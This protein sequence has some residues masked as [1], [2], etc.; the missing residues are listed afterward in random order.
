MIKTVICEIYMGKRI[1]TFETN[2]PALE[3]CS[4]LTIVQFK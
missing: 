3:R 1:Q 2:T 4:L